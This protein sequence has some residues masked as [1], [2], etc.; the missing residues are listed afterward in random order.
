[1]SVSY[2]SDVVGSY[3]GMRDVHLCKDQ[4]NI[5]RPG[6]TGSYRFLSG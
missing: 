2:G 3:F 6:F 1:M 4:N 5:I